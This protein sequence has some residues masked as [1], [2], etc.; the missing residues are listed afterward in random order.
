MYRRAWKLD[1]QNA[2]LLLFFIIV[3]VVIRLHKPP[4]LADLISVCV[5]SEL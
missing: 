4:G 5:Q 2:I 1:T 3:V